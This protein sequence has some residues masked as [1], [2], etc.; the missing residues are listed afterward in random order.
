MGRG[1]IAEGYN[2]RPP[3]L[4]AVI[5]ATSP[6]QDSRCSGSLGE[7]VWA[8][9]GPE[10]PADLTKRFWGCSAGTAT[11]SLMA[12]ETT[13]ASTTVTVVDPRYDFAR[14]GVCTKEDVESAFGN[15][16]SRWDAITEGG[17]YEMDRNG[18]GWWL[19]SRDV[20][21]SDVDDFEVDCE[22][23]VYDNEW[24]AAVDM[25]YPALRDVS[26][27]WLLQLSWESRFDARDWINKTQAY[28]FD[29]LYALRSVDQLENKVAVTNLLMRP[30]G[31]NRV[32]SI[33]VRNWSLQH[34]G[35]DTLQAVMS[36]V[37]ARLAGSHA[38]ITRDT[39]AVSA[40]G[41]GQAIDQQ[42]GSEHV[43]SDVFANHGR[44]H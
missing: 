27:D 42:L 9:I 21:I 32:A 15:S 28:G 38:A 6:L 26:D 36:E 1:I 12:G 37:R 44:R 22:A 20:W 7:T 25:G 43:P 5:T 29:A 19:Y 23:W 10:P 2:L 41:A 31:D 24:S 13:L 11:V 33:S 39:L 40:E 18:R 8:R 14:A 34:V 17:W 30:D 3:D 35:A 4:D 16:F